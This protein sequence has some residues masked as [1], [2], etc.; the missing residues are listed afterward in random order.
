M[1]IKRSTQTRSNLSA[2]FRDKKKRGFFGRLWDGIKANAA[3]ILGIIGTI[4]GGVVGGALGTLIGG[5]L[6]DNPNIEFSSEK[7]LEVN[8]N[9]DEYPISE[10]EENVL[11]HFVKNQFL[12][13]VKNMALSIDAELQSIG[14]KTLVLASYAPIDIVNK[15]LKE[16]SILKNYALVISEHGERV[17]AYSKSKRSENYII[18]KVEVINSFLDQLEKGVLKY[19]QD[20]GLDSFVLTVS[21]TPLNEFKSVR[22]IPLDWQS[23]N[24][25]GAIKKYVKNTEATGNLEIVEVVN[26][27]IE[28]TLP[29]TT[30]NEEV[31]TTTPKKNGTVKTV[32]AFTGIALIIER[33]LR[34][35]NQNHK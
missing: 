31:V 9:E 11:M 25:T 33:V 16:I 21:D 1:I 23:Q 35:N 10:E 18:N 34:S 22:S 3:T 20:N 26:T 19:V 27:D 30:T 5:W 6:Q 24:V 4:G 15:A 29:A 17:S 28:N 13:A 14:N 12:P 8:Y 7:T 32:L 2:F